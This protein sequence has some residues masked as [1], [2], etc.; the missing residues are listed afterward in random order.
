MEKPVVLKISK[1]KK[2]TANHVTLFFKFP[3]DF[4]PG[5]FVMVWLPRVDE[6]PFTLSY[7]NKEEFGITIESKGAFTKKVINMKAGD[8]LGVRGP[9]GKS[10]TI[11]QRFNEVC[12]VAGGCGMAPIAPL[13]D[14]LYRRKMNV[15]VIQGARSKSSLLFLDRYKKIKYCTDDGSK[16]YKGYTTSLL[17]EELRK[18]KYDLVY[19]CGPEIMM[20]S[21]FEICESCGVPIEVSLERYMRC[22]FGV[23][24]ACVCGKERVC[25]DGP[26]FSLKKLR[27]MDDFGKSA[28]LKNGMEVSLDKYFS[29]RC[30]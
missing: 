5:Q 4:K 2:E 28:L 18:K 8:K 9:Y 17:Q 21:A 3:L 6:K 30:K 11:K 29:W 16:G 20:R 25:I 7:H 1:V 15:T 24:G 10:F 19:A 12:V 23:C 22:G 13:I 27:K 14:E 26:V